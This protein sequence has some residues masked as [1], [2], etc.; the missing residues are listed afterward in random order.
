MRD[1]LLQQISKVL[2]N[3]IIRFFLVSGLN[4]AFGYGLFALLI[5]I[6]LHYTIAGL[7]G[8]ILGILF[9]FKTTGLLV[10]ESNKN[11]LILKFIGVYGIN[12]V[13][14][15][16]LLTLLERSGVDAFLS[17]SLLQVAGVSLLKNPR[18]NACI[19]A[20]ILIIPMGLFAYALNHRFVFTKP[21]LFPAKKGIENQ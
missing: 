7:I 10:F 1:H 9:N 3:K 19:G 21:D 13:I 20:A 4:T 8:T 14:S 6:G 12:Y 11:R 15:M 5:F 18:I 17:L 16:S 2:K